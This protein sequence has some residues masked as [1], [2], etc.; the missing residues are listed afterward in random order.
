VGSTPTEQGI[1][2][3]SSPRTTRLHSDTVDRLGPNTKP[4]AEAGTGCPPYRVVGDEAWSH[5]FTFAHHRP[6]D[7]RAH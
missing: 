2:P 7:R 4:V 5:L 6:D 3:N 1:G